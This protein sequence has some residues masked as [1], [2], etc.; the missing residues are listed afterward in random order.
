M[1]ILKYGIIGG[2]SAF[3]LYLVLQIVLSIGDV[4]GAIGIAT[5]TLSVI[6]CSCTGILLDAIKGQNLM[7]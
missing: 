4:T 3:F 2:F 7:K 6:I 1:R 5:I